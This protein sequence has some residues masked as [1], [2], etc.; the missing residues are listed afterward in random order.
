MDPGAAPAFCV[1]VDQL[2]LEPLLNQDPNRMAS[3]EVPFMPS[4]PFAANEGPQLTAQI[5]ERP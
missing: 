1:D 5:V 4:A 2:G 3:F